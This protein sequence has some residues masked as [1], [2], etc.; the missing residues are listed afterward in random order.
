MASWVLSTVAS[1]DV[2]VLKKTIGIGSI[3]VE[4]IVVY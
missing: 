1:D 4:Y 3:D 2:C